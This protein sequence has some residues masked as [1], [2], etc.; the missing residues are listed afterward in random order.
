[1]IKEIIS[2]SKPG[3][4]NLHYVGKVTGTTFISDII[5]EVGLE[6]SEILCN[7]GFNPGLRNQVLCQKNV[8]ALRYVLKI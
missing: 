5:R 1:M 7:H 4:G 3:L 2:K 6:Q 8:N